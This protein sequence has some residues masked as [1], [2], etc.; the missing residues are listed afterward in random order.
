MTF[1]ESLFFGSISY[2]VASVTVVNNGFY[3]PRFGYM[4]SS[5]TK[6]IREFLMNFYDGLVV[7]FTNEKIE[8]LLGR[9]KTLYEEF[10]NLSRK[11]QKEQLYKYIRKYNELH[12]VYFLEI[13]FCKGCRVF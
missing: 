11:K 1:I 2:L 5:T 12:P 13:S 9:D 10:K 7:E 6:E 4:G 8:Q 3:D